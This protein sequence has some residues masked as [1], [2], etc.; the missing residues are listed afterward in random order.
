M[1]ILLV[2][3]TLS[4]SRIALV[5]VG[6]RAPLLVYSQ[7]PH[8]QVVREQL[9]DPT[10]VRLCLGREWYRHHSAFLLPP[11]WELA[12]IKSGF[13]GQLP[14]PFESAPPNGSRLIPSNMNHL[15][16]EEPTRYVPVNSCD[17]MVDMDRYS[18]RQFEP[19]YSFLKDEWEVIYSI[20][21]LDL[22]NTHRRLYRAFYIPV[23]S[24]RNAV[25][26]NYNLLRAQRGPLGSSNRGGPHTFRNEHCVKCD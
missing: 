23:L 11:D 7:L 20:P 22:M 3:I 26:V 2:F 9:A 12:F 4:L 18:D 19:N 1:L 13:T 24:A 21:Y 10:R 16:L 17:F 15:N 8:V 25:F 5:L 6:F 14:K